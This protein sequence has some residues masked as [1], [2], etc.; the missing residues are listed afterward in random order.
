M[1]TKI[2]RYSD[3]NGEKRW[4]ATRGKNNVANGG[5]G[6]KRKITRNRTL[7]RLLQSIKDGNYVIID[8]D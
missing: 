7:E 8:L 2:Y 6:Y 3:V 1:K 4:K 5:E